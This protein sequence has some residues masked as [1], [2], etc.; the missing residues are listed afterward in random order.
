VAK[1]GPHPLEGFHRNGAPRKAPPRPGQ[2]RLDYAEALAHYAKQR[3]DH[4]L[5]AWMSEIRLRAITQ[6][7]KISRELEKAERVRTDP[8]RHR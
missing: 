5:D 7:G 8:A 1:P 2:A 3:D 4:E 6:I